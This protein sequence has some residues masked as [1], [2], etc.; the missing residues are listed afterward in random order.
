MVVYFFIMHKRKSGFTLVE[1]MVT[2]VIL[3]ILAAIAIPTYKKYTMKAKMAEAYVGVDALTKSE[4]TYFISNKDFH[5]YSSV[6]GMAQIN[7]LYNADTYV[8]EANQFTSKIA[9]PFPTGSRVRFYYQAAGGRTNAAGTELAG[10]V[11]GTGINGK[12]TAGGT[13]SAPGRGGTW[14]SPIQWETYA[15]AAGKSNYNWYA[16]MAAKDLDPSNP[17]CTRVM[18]FIDTDTK[19]KLN[20][21]TG[22]VTVNPGT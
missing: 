19:G 2:V 3:G 21:G 11:D 10:D 18:R 12:I 14:C 22:F 6:Y 4:A 16:I 8:L 7:A 1:L 9:H 20:L 13:H 15:S 5:Q 17:E